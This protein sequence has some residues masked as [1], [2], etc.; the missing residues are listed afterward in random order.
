MC[1]CAHV[2]ES[3]LPLA[4]A[5][6][7]LDLPLSSPH[8]SRFISRPCQSPGEVITNQGNTGLPG[9]GLS[10]YTHHLLS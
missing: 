4:K 6:I 8:T 2:C 10:E 7:P 3:P 5:I 1:V 9:R